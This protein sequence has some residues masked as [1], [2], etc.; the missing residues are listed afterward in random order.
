MARKAKSVP[1]KTG[2]GLPDTLQVEPAARPVRVIVSN[3][4]RDADGKLIPQK[5]KVAADPKAAKN[6]RQAILEAFGILGGVR[7]LV[8]HAKKNPKDFGALLAKAMPQDINVTGTFG[9]V[10][11]AVPVE[12]RE[13]IPGELM[14]P[15]ALPFGLKVAEVQEAVELDPFT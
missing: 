7:W 9:Y 3:L 5:N 1:R 4:P 14:Q 10:P 15:A 11:M 12:Q 13:P 2:K 8:K 6:P